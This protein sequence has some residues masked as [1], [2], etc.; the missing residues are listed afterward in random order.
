MRSLL[1]S[2][3]QT[4]RNLVRSP[5]FT[6][7]AIVTLALGMAATTIIYST[8]HS[9]ML[10]P[11]PFPESQELYA[12]WQE[13]DNGR[14]A[15]GP[16]VGLVRATLD[17]PRG[18]AGIAA[19]TGTEHSL[20]GHGEPVMLRGAATTA[21]LPDLLGVRPIIGRY[22]TH[23]DVR[24]AAQVVLI[25]E[26]VWRSR[27]GGETAVLGTTI[28]LGPDVRTVI[29]VMP[30]RFARYR[31]YGEAHE[32][33]I[34]VDWATARWGV[35]LIV[36][37]HKTTDSVAAA[38][39]LTALAA[40][41]PMGEGSH[42]EGWTYSLRNLGAMAG[43]S[44][45][46]RKTVPRL[47][48]AAALLLL[49]G[50]ANVAGLLLV[51]L[52][53]RRREL[54]VRAAI[55]ARL[56]HLLSELAAE[57]FII[58]AAAG[59]LGVLLAIWGIDLIRA[60]RPDQLATLDNVA[61]SLPVLIFAGALVIITTLL[62]GSLPALA[63]VRADLTT[64]LQSAGGPRLTSGT[65]TRSILVTMQLALSTLLLVGGFLLVRTMQRLENTDLGF[66]H[67][68]LLVAEIPLPA[69]RYDT[70]SR[71]VLVDDLVAALADSHGIDGVAVST[72]APPHMGLMF[73]AG[74]EVEGSDASTADIQ[75]LKGGGVSPG[76]FS[77]MGARIEEGR[78]YT[79]G[80]QERTAVVN[81]S[82][83]ERFWPGESAVGR[84][85]RL[86]PSQDWTTIVGVVNDLR[87]D[88]PIH[89]GE[90]MYFWPMS[91]ATPSVTITLRMPGDPYAAAPLLRQHLARFDADLP[92]RHITSMEERMA[93]TIAAQ[94]FNMVM[95]GVF[96]TAAALLC[97]IGLYGLVSYSFEQRVREVGV[98][99]ALGATPRIIQSLFM[100]QAVRLAA[101]GVPLGLIGAFA[102][103]QVTA[104][105]V[106]DVGPRDPLAYGMAFLVIVLV[107]LPA[108][109]LPARRA[110]RTEVVE[111]LRR[112]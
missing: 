112:E 61:V 90:P 92:I 5:A 73:A 44:F 22:F 35:S 26:S 12:V 59:V 7:S 67:E 6:A 103:A 100:S 11:L 23:Q 54:A 105:L 108:G 8:F 41:M 18:F 72:G 78:E 40:S 13:R 3:R 77:T 42:G 93:G 70:A 17:D 31:E 33:W 38:A 95:L 65:R 74:L 2:L 58:A 91:Y 106:H 80:P 69:Y 51:R 20:T 81:R 19:Y 63:I 87:I 1:T 94:R 9:L 34:P 24:E 39:S 15:T 88:G 96:A 71:E 16:S 85:F 86:D 57:Q 79:T 62:F 50:C 43:A 10:R 99:I 55:G 109:W 53:A 28:R 14:L 104:A 56:R 32:Y 97:A 89:G 4:M 48:A 101:I 27:F 49:I 36:R 76:F 46:A 30:S 83:V 52:H 29:G 111:A 21:G 68:R 102:S 66:D 98:R 60:V 75:Y 107:V 45:N 25:S 84:R 47:F 82:F 37:A 64:S 110:A